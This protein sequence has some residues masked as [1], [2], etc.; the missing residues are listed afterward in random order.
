M[1]NVAT[2]KA[3]ELAYHIIPDLEGADVNARAQE[4]NDLIAQNGGSVSVSKEPRKIHLSYPIKN[5]NYAYF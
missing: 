3:Y 4:L 5:K 1:E 2:T